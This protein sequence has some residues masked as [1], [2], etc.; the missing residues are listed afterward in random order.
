MEVLVLYTSKTGNTESFVDWFEDTY[1]NQFNIDSINLYRNKNLDL[2]NFEKYDKIILGM[3]TWSNG[4][5]PIEMK[6]IIICNREIIRNKVA[7]LFGSGIT[8]YKNFCG[9][10]DNTLIILDKK[11]PVIKNELTFLPQESKERTKRIRKMIHDTI[12]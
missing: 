6:N 4:K 3:Y 12:K 5:I 1:A 2:I 7:F 8:I 9:A 11:V 10:L